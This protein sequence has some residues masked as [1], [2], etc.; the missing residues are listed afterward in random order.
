MDYRTV[1]QLVGAVRQGASIDDA[2]VLRFGYT[3]E[4]AEVDPEWI[5]SS[6][7]HWGWPGVTPAD[8]PACY[9]VLRDLRVRL[10]E[11]ERP[12]REAIAERMA[13]QPAPALCWRC[14]REQ[15][16]DLDGGLCQSCFDND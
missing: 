5:D 14:H 11:L 16:T 1:D 9:A 15:A 7:Q 13:R 3:I 12:A 2:T 6:G 10:N 4:Y 8:V